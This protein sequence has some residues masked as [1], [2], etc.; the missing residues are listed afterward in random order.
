MHFAGVDIGAVATKACIV[1][2]EGKLLAYAISKTTADMSKTG[3]ETLK[4]CLKEAGLKASD[5]RYTVATGYGGNIALLTFANE[6]FTEITCHSKGARLLF[7]KCHTVIDIGGQDSKVIGLNDAGKVSRFVMNDT[8]AAG[9]GRFLEVMA[10]ILGV[11]LEKMGEFSLES[12]NKV[13][14]TSTCT[15][16]AESEVISLIASGR[17]PVDIIAGLHDAIARRVGGLVKQVGA[18]DDVVITGG[19]AKNIG[20]VS[21]LEKE[22]GHKIH[23]PMEP[24]IIGA[25]GAAII[26]KEK[27]SIKGL[28]AT[29]DS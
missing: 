21:A 29:G 4:R 24:Q 8:C 23:V 15:V 18:K 27:A 28:N 1:D 10:E 11:K 17:K 22:I 13:Q 5:I 26:A 20:V 3:N 12:K 14:I 6:K 16:F 9:T 7:P 25:L 2:A 19:V